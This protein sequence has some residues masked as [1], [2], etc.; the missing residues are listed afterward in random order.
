MTPKKFYCFT[1]M[2]AYT[3]KSIGLEADRNLCCTAQTKDQSTA[4]LPII[5]SSHIELAINAML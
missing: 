4:S 1:A 5:A 3:P 2:L